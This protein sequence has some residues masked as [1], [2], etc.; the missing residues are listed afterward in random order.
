MVKGQDFTNFNRGLEELKIPLTGKQEEQFLSY[1]ELLTEGNARMNLTTITAWDE[2]VRKHFLDSLC[3][4]KAF[5]DLRTQRVIDVGTGAGF[6][7][8]PLKI[9][10]PEI[11]LVLADSV[12]KKL[13]F[14]DAVIEKLKLSGVSTVHGRAEDLARESAYRQQF[15]LCVSRAVAD[16]SVLAEY[17]LPFVRI[18]GCFVAYKS[19][20][21]EEEA[22][23]A[24]RAVFSL[25]GEREDMVFY[26]LPGAREGRS[27]IRVRKTK[28]TP[29]RYPRKAG[30]PEK[31]PLR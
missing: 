25:G 9:A 1:Y 7:G 14:L 31:D 22:K 6:P 17:C 23:R 15:D 8:L 10:F 24:D 13:S 12:G 26:T 18:G 27:L 11:D 20:D 28:E 30:K 16:L 21:A 3:L 29:R 19:A 2:V 4:V 5:P